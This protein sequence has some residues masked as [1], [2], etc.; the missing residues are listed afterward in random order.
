MDELE[1]ARA[2]LRNEERRREYLATHYHNALL[3]AV[4]L[5]DA[6]ERILKTSGEHSVV[7]KIAKDAL[8]QGNAPPP[9]PSGV[10]KIPRRFEGRY[11]DVRMTS[12]FADVTP[13]AIFA[14]E[15]T[16]DTDREQL[17]AAGRIIG[18]RIFPGLVNMVTGEWQSIREVRAQDGPHRGTAFK[19][20]S[21]PNETTCEVE[22]L[23][24]YDL[25]ESRFTGRA[26]P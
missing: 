21:W 10:I 3:H 12:K 2:Q 18:Q 4:K 16:E 9:E 1:L 11:F 25:T 7:G 8:D 5:Q 17:R 22:V 24:E 6:L 26:W 13:E 19:V 20:A 15:R 14:W 23:M